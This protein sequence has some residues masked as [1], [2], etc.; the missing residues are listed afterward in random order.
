MVCCDLSSQ[1]LAAWVIARLV[2]AEA[3]ECAIHYVAPVG[4]KEEYTAHAMR[5][6]EPYLH[7]AA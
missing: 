5:R 4:E 6:I 2:G 1:Y 7:A 3:A